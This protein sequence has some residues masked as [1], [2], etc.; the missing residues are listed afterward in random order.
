MALA[1]AMDTTALTYDPVVVDEAQDFAE[2]YWLPIELLLARSEDNYLYVFFD[3][4]QALYHQAAKPPVN[5]DPF[6]LNANCRNTS[7]IHEAAYRYYF[8][9]ITDAPTIPGAP[10][11]RLVANGVE[12]QAKT[13]AGKVASLIDEERVDPADVAVLVIAGSSLRW[14]RTA[15]KGRAGPVRPW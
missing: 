9:E 11:E 15:S 1:L 4:N 5:D 6:L 7:V 10:I 12:A 8:G 3:Y 13:I 2:E 14:C